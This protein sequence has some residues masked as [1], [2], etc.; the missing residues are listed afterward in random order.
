[1]R[2][3]GW[4]IVCFKPHFFLHSHFF[5]FFFPLWLLPLYMA[6]MLS[7]TWKMVSGRNIQFL[8]GICV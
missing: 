1:M 4:D 7:Y 2:G 3:G 8:L 6:K 5:F